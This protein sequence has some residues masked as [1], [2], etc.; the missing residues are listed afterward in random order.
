MSNPFFISNGPF[1]IS[2]IS[3]ILNIEIKGEKNQI[4]KDIKDLLSADKDCI[5]FCFV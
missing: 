2:E 3:K 1:N 4:I 5:T